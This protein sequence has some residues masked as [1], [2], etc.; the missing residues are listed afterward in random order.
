MIISLLLAHIEY[1]WIW[2]NFNWI[3]SDHRAGRPYSLCPVVGICL[4]ASSLQSAVSSSQ[5]WMLSLFY[6]VQPQL[7][8]PAFV[9]SDL[10]FP[11]PTR[12][13]WIPDVET[14]TVPPPW[15]RG[16]QAGLRSC[17]LS[18]LCCHSSHS[19]L[20]RNET[21][22]SVKASYPKQRC[23]GATCPCPWSWIATA[24][25]PHGGVV[26]SYLPTLHLSHSPGWFTVLASEFS[27]AKLWVWALFLSCEA[28]LGGCYVE[29]LK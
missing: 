28:P 27:S 4:P 8:P 10:A 20:I 22:F 23:E 21:C 26:F 1:F 13:F 25:K 3:E 19:C 11:F 29:T 2:I 5:V 14:V 18:C 9:S 12:D 24:L 16:C 15:L 7:A 6:F 17:P